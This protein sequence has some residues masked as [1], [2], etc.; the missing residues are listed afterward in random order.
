MRT[1]RGRPGEQRPGLSGPR[2]P[3]GRQPLRKHTWSMRPGAAQPCE[4]LDPGHGAASKPTWAQAPRDAPLQ[5]R[6]RSPSELPENIFLE[7]RKTNSLA[8]PPATSGR[9]T[10]ATPNTTVTERSLQLRPRP[11]RAWNIP[12]LIEGGWCWQRLTGTSSTFNGQTPPHHPRTPPPLEPMVSSRAP[13]ILGH[14]APGVVQGA[15]A[16][17]RHGCR[18]VVPPTLLSSR[19]LSKLVG[20]CELPIAH[21]VRGDIGPTGGCC[22]DPMI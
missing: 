16:G 8:S 17:L 5:S 20:V 4:T 9:H 2:L 13:G 14:E 11:L 19:V 1:P 22:E 15:C 12:F 3:R 21:L 18:D 7:T 6:P 10:H